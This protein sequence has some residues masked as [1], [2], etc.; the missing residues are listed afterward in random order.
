M[1]VPVLLFLAQTTLLPTQ[2]RLFSWQEG[3]VL[4]QRI[5]YKQV[6]VPDTPIVVNGKSVTFTNWN[7]T[8]TPRIDIQHTLIYIGFSA[9]QCFVMAGVWNSGVWSPT[10]EQVQVQGPCMVWEAV[11]YPPT[12]NALYAFGALGYPY[13]GARLRVLKTPFVPSSYGLSSQGLT[14]VENNRGN[15]VTVAPVV[16]P[17]N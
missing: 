15:R 12:M 10:S 14:H 11:G 5:N 13:P 2:A 16:G 8:I 17:A 9:G 3:T 6:K 1:L 4:R 7:V